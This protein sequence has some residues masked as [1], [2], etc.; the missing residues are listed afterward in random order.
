MPADKP[1]A[2]STLTLGAPAAERDITQ[3]LADYF[4][5]S[6][7][8]R[9][10]T[11]GQKRIV[12]GNRGTGKSAIFNVLAE[13]R[14]KAKDA[15]IE[16]AP[17]DYSYEMLS[18]IL[19]AESEGSWAKHGAYA[20]A[21]KYLI[22]VLV[23]KAVVG[24]AT[25]MKKG[26]AGRIQRYLRDKHGADHG[27]KI[28]MLI[29]YLKRME[30]V[31]LG[32][33]EASIKTRQLDQMYKLDEITPLLD[34][35]V[36]ALKGRP[37]IVLVDELDRGWDASEDAKAFVA[38][39]FQACAKLNELSPQLR[40]YMSLRQE[41]YDSIPSLYEDAQKARDMI[42]VIAWDEAHC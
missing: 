2:L 29:G 36:E 27:S 25:R 28:S 5:E 10:V 13:R 40:V 23:M 17:E 19:A 1:T 3:G 20:V 35:L 12:L 34:D 42:E 8:F 41:L 26:P 7:A 15:V 30:G 14:R 6:E 9:R 16:L 21:W 24:D 39:L 4:V 33:V 38:G 11:E 22:Y 31:K 32:P 37:V 18:T